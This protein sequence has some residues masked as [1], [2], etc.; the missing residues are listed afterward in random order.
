M[1]GTLRYGRQGDDAK[2]VDQTGVFLARDAASLDSACDSCRVRKVCRV[3]LG[4]ELFH[5]KV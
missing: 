5:E 4:T 1:F 3:P 2:F